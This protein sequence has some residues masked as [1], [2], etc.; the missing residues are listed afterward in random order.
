MG[1]LRMQKRRNH[2]GRPVLESPPAPLQRIR[3]NSG[4]S[5]E[6]VS[7]ISGI[8]TFRVSRHERGLRLLPEPEA[9]IWTSVVLAGPRNDEEK[10]V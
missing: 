2:P 8:S 7:E 1:D 6:R 4:L 10:K 3:L 9:R 5:L